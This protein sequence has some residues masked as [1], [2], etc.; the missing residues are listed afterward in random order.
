MNRLRRLVLPFGD[1][2]AVLAANLVAA[3]L[4][5]EFDWSQMSLRDH[6]VFGITLL[7]LAVTPV[8]FRLCGLY[9]GTWK[10]TGLDDLVRLSQAVAY[11]AIT[12]VVLVYGGISGVS[13]A[14]LILASLL[15]LAFAGGIRLLPRFTHEVRGSRRRVGGR[16]TLIIGAG[17]TGESLLRELRKGNEGEFNPIGFLDDDPAKLRATIHGVPVVGTGADLKGRIEE[18]GIRE[19]I[20]AVPR[21]SRP[22]MLEIFE[23]CREAGVRLRTVPTLGELQRGAARIGQIRMVEIEDLLGREVVRL[24]LQ[25]LREGLRGRRVLV[26]GAAGSIGRELSR[27]VAAQD[28]AELIVL[29]RNENNLFYLDAEL[30]QAQPLLRFRAVVGDV[31][32]QGRMTAL[33]EASRPEIVLHAAA[34]K[35][36]PLMEDHPLEAIRNNV[37]ATRRLA[38][39][40]VAAGVARFIYISTDKAVRPTSVMGATKRLGERLVKSL[41]GERTRFMAVRFGNVLGSDGS[42]IPTFR[43]QIAAGGP[44][45][46]THP[47]ATRYF[48]TI[49][50]AVQLV[51]TA[52]IMGEGGEIFLLRMGEPVRIVD[53]ARQ[54]I[55]LSGLRPD[56]DI[57]IAFTGLRPGEKLH[58]E[59]HNEAEHAL[60]TSNEKILILSG[61]ERLT[62]A[63]TAPL[64]RLEQAVEHGDAA[65]AL[66]ALRTLVPEYIPARGGAAGEEER[67]ESRIVPLVGKRRIDAQN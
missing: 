1:I 66:A 67:E 10:Y 23:T 41:S 46:V 28:P 38:E 37:L 48:M 4:R 62:D 18:L 51:L 49:P 43:R 33:L 36:V 44:V 42:V 24:D 34:Y 35:H 54:L 64:A 5:F 16:R 17:D 30:R 27:Q 7:D 58:E 8:I 40:S 20:L 2:V 15:L 50:E 57:K 26:T 61:V 11:R 25:H 21:A 6:H 63:E 55:E 9:R 19:V 22:W 14:I 53:L 52:G 39:A 59:V 56:Q 31:L 60:A 47:E 3:A 65:G 32:D 12:L 45:T 13:R 29:D